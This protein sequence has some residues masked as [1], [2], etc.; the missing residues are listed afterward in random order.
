MAALLEVDGISVNL[1][2]LTPE[3]E[4]TLRLC[5]LYEQTDGIEDFAEAL[6]LDAAHPDTI[7]LYDRVHTNYVAIW[8]FLG[9]D[10][11][12]DAMDARPHMRLVA[13]EMIKDQ[14]G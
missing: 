8:N 2:D 4:M 7:E 9:N 14:D 5:A 12:E 6:E 11:F 3:E 1:A 13:R 10:Q